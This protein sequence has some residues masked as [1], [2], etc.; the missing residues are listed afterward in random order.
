MTYTVYAVRC[1]DYDLVDE[2]VAEL[3]DM[4]GGINKYIKPGDRVALKPNLLQAA[5]PDKAITTHPRVVE[6]VGNLVNNS[7]A[8][9]ILVESPTGAYP[10]TSGTL[11]RVYRATGMVEAATRAG[12][13]LSY[14]TRQEEVSFME[15]KLTKHFQICSPIL[16]ADL[17]INLPKF[18]TH[19]LT[20]VTGAVKNLFGVI[21]GRAKPGYHAT[22]NDKYLFAA[23]LLDLAAFIS[24]GLTIMDAV[25]GMEGNGPGN[26]DPR[27]VGL[28]LGSENPLALDLVMAE[29]MGLPKNEN[30]YLVEAE[31]QGRSPITMDEI[32]LV[33]IDSEEMRI[34]DF[35]LPDTTRS[36]TRLRSAS[37]LQDALFPIF[38]NSMTLQPLV[39]PADCIACEDCVNI[40]P[41]DVIEIVD[42]DHPHALIDDDGCIRCYCCHETCPEDA[43]ELHKNLLYRVVRG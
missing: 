34:P 26:G 14:D 16:E 41:M 5:K 18:K 31:K 4:M 6:A 39:I 10:H 30:P 12:I 1:P 8:K 33:G 36:D 3:L 11:E 38:R 35:K 28:L 37:W 24:P 13:E 15:G 17:V 7:G 40:C 20:A 2:K 22:L 21:P 32:N 23:M 19:A 43:I 9:S 27:Q 29:M 42:G 25:V